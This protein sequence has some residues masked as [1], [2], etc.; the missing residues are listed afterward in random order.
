RC[1]RRADASPTTLPIAC[2]QEESACKLAKLGWADHDKIIASATRQAI[3]RGDTPIE[4]F[5]RDKPSP[6]D[7]FQGK[8]QRRRRCVRTCE[9][10]HQAHRAND[11]VRQN[12]AE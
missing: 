11:A 2:F 6:S 8:K 10:D 4:V 12:G 7:P 3:P 9:T 5:P 1:G